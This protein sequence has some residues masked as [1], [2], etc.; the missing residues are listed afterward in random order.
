MTN[1]GR[2]IS[3]CWTTCATSP[4]RRR[5]PPQH[6]QDER[7]CSSQRVICSGGNG[8]RSCLGCPGRPP[9]APPPVPAGL[10]GRCGLTRS[11]DGGLEE[12]EEFFWAA[13]SCSR[14]W[15][16]SARKAASCACW[17]LS[18]PCSRRHLAQG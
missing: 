6:G 17:E 11:E 9:M 5:S 7:T 16:T 3:T 8:A 12:V 4:L 14:S 18:C 1:G 15:A 10:P 2:V 13:A